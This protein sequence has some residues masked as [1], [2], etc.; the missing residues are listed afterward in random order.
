M[1]AEEKVIQLNK[2]L[3]EDIE[4]FFNE[5]EVGS[6]GTRKMY[7]KDIRQ[8]FRV[9]RDK[10]L[11]HLTEG[12]LKIKKK[13]MIAYRK[14]LQDNFRL[15]NN[16]INNKITAVKSLYQFLSDEYEV[17][18]TAFNFKSLKTQENPYGNLSQSEAERF[19]ET[20]Y[21]I[22]REKPELKRLLI[23]FAIR[24]SFRLSEILSL[25]WSDFDD[26]DRSSDHVK[27]SVIGKGQKLNTTS[28]H[29]S[30]YDQLIE[31]KDI[32]KNY[33]WRN[34]DI[35]FQISENAVNDM[36]KRIKKELNIGDNRNIVFHSFRGIA[37]D[38]EYHENG[39]L[40][41]VQQA[42]HSNMNTAYK[43]YINK[44]RDFSNTA[45]VRMDREFSLEFIDNLT[46]EDFREFFKNSE[47]RIQKEL[48]NYYERTLKN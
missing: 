24:S 22:E 9:Y 21:M 35:V 16:T 45:G 28:I 31:L 33:N 48:K 30:F 26:Y 10:E 2:Y 8:F 6:K 1:R 34:P 7:E 14:Y 15:A 3:F 20:A 11:E 19:A 47:L 13:D 42:N 37:I 18:M 4:A 38:M 5:L 41:A 32:N 44:T 43:H 25:K 36:M 12:D 40:A 46:L 27:V 29:R 39:I 17:N 23:L